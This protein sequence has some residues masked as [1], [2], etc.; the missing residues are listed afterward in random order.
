MRFVD[1][2]TLTCFAG[3]GGPGAVAFRREKYVDKGGPSGGNGGRG[4]DVIL[5]ADR[6]VG[7]LLDLRYRH[8]VKAEDGRPGQPRLMDGKDAEDITV[9]VPVGTLVRDARDG[10]LLADLAED[11]ERFVVAQGGRG[12]LG[13]ARFRSSVRQVPRFA[14]PGEPGTHRPIT[15]ELKL[16]ADLG[17][18]GFP[19]VGKSTLISVIS[20]ARPKIADYPF[21]TLTPNL[22]L[23][24]WRDER[25]FVVADIPGLIEGAH[26]GEGL[27]FQ[28]LR[29]VERCR[30][31]LHVIEVTPQMEG[32]PDG[33]EPL[34]DHD[35]I[36]R[37]LQL[38]SPSL[39]ER[40]QIVGLGKMD[41]PFVRE[42][43]PELRAHFEGLGLTFV[44]FSAATRDGLQPLLDA[45]GTLVQNTPPPDVAHFTAVEADPRRIIDPDD[46]LDDDPHP[47]DLVD[48][49]TSVYVRDED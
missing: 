46:D 8:E 45:I 13:N 15:L 28:F 18:I 40:P 31:L 29:H 17:I 16:L 20:N 12:G 37:E 44:A 26:R 41:L 36:Q 14:Q 48:D 30:A 3:H 1:A 22:G 11:G 27:G 23:V 24:R 47:D 7:T 49:E 6:N 43:E 34:A 21:T 2:V 33:R 39:A 9:R 5:L 42:R 32:V 19:S 38:F 25:S 35:A 10:E 4:G